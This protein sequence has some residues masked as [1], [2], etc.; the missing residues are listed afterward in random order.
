[1]VADIERRFSYFRFDSL[2]YCIRLCDFPV[3]V[4]AALSAMTMTL[5]HEIHEK[6]NEERQK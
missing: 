4:G 2:L 6:L 5:T 1:M 3:S